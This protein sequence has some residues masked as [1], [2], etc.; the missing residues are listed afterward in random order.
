M[1]TYWRIE[2]HGE[3]VFI[4]KNCGHH[5]DAPYEKCPDCGYKEAENNG[6]A[7]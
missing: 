3:D 5:Q 6:K 2:K 1:R 7:D 4:C